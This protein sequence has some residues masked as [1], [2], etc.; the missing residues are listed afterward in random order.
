[1][2]YE[3]IIVPPP[4]PPRATREIPRGTPR[5]LLITS[6]TNHDPSDLLAGREVPGS[7]DFYF[8]T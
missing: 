8:N 5:K 3:F 6:R 7:R 4:P 2:M 1:M